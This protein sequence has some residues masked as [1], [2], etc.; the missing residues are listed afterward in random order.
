MFKK[1]TSSSQGPQHPVRVWQ[2]QK[3]KEGA[4]VRRVRGLHQGTDVLQVRGLRQGR[5]ADEDQQADLPGEEVPHEGGAQEDGVG[6]SDILDASSSD[7][8]LRMLF[9]IIRFQV[10]IC[11]LRF[12]RKSPCSLK[13]KEISS[14]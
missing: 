8:P 9:D 11:H 6:L 13:T 7:T 14:R 1:P 12:H 2:W 3:L 5:R 4:A 10:E